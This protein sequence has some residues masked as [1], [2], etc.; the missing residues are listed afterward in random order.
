MSYANMVVDGCK[1]LIEAAQRLSVPVIV[2]EQYPKGLGVTVSTLR[3]L[4]PEGAI[5][6]KMHFSCLGDAK[7]RDR[8]GDLGRDQIII[9]GIEAHVCV[10]QT[11]LGLTRHG[12]MPF[13]VEDA[14]SS[15]TQENRAS[16]IARLRANDVE[17]VTSEMVLF[18]WLGQAGTDAFRELSG[19]LR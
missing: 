17:T 16:A 10:L 3:D 5:A 1:V 11:A 2:S 18:E 7:L 15:R 19:L 8:I 9:G 6:P 4:V 12:L 13:V 14:V